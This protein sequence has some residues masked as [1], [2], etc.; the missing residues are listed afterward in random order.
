MR[1]IVE[2][3]IDLFAKNLFCVRNCMGPRKTKYEPQKQQSHSYCAL[4]HNFLLSP[5]LLLFYISLTLMFEFYFFS[6]SRA[7]AKTHRFALSHTLT[8]RQSYLVSAGAPTMWSLNAFF[9]KKF[10]VGLLT[11]C[12]PAKVVDSHIVNACLSQIT[13]FVLYIHFSESQIRLERCKTWLPSFNDI[14][15]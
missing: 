1:F 10:S 9:T 8:F 15:G 13:R 5:P 12:T 2:L 14:F 3:Y 7:V 11:T 4:R 6:I